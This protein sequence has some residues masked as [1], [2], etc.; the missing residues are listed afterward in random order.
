M[1][2]YIAGYGRSGSTILD[3]KLGKE[4]G[5]VS[6]GE[7]KSLYY[8]VSYYP[9]SKCGC[10][11]TY[12]N[13]LLWGQI[14]SSG[15]LLEKIWMTKIYQS[16]R[17]IGFLFYILYLVRFWRLPKKATFLS[18]VKEGI[19]RVR[20]QYPNGVYIDSS[21]TTWFS[22]RRPIILSKLGYSIFVIHIH[23]PLKDVLTSVRSGDNKVLMGDRRKEKP[24]RVLR[25]TF[26][27]FFANL[28]AALLKTKFPY[29]QISQI[30][31][32]DHEAKTFEKIRNFI[33]QQ[34]LD[35]HE[36]YDISHVVSGNRLKFSRKKSS[37]DAS[38]E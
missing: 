22:V 19:E 21:K 5:F 11:S 20:T 1:I 35:G 14:V 7:I 8:E 6:L 30:D 4:F 32:R 23:R 37:N 13:C 25:A 33:A 2:L 28:Y 27:Y 24:L 12:Q 9:A 31:L 29:L 26:S 3:I 17:L 15:N 34:K 36:F 38:T 10:G 16:P 18:M